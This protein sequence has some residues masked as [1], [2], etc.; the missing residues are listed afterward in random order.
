ML[1]SYRDFTRDRKP[2]VID[3]TGIEGRQATLPRLSLKTYIILRNLI[4]I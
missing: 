1:R 4:L 3:A 2:K